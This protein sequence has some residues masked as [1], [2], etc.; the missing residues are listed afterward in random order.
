MEQGQRM[1]LYLGIEMIL[2]FFKT[3]N[4]LPFH[5]FAQK[6]YEGLMQMGNLG[7]PP[8]S[9]YL[10]ELERY[11]FI[12][13]GGWNGTKNRKRLSKGA[14]RTQPCDSHPQTGWAQDLALIFWHNLSGEMA[15]KCF[16]KAP[17]E[18]DHG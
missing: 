13:Y 10:Q 15:A 16:G 6:T 17:G 8:D 3:N 9:T 7:T 12:E 4:Q 18:S 11:L 2:G 5:R 14:T 1:S